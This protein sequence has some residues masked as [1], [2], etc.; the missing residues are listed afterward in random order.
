VEFLRP[1]EGSL[2]ETSRQ[3]FE[4]NPLRV[5]DSK[6]PQD[7]EIVANAPSVLDVLGPEDIA[8]F[9]ALKR[10]LDA[11][12]VTYTVDAGLVRGLDYYTRTLFEIRS[13]AGE[14]GAQNT[15][16]GGG[17]YDGMVRSLGG[18]PVPAIGFA[19]GLER[20]LL[21]M[22]DATPAV[23][24][25]CFIAPIGERATAVGLSLARD[26]RSRG[27]RAELDGRGNSVKSMMRRADAA[28]ARL[29]IVLGD[30]E[31]ATAEVVIKDLRDREMAPEAVSVS[32]AAARVAERLRQIVAE[33]TS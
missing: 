1:L 23:T 26:V 28:G 17:R 33:G 32:E 21:A 18:P 15:L 8:H 3:R 9:E 10:H 14:L 6:A 24:P 5:L 2:S 16:V 12:G 20:I 4:T 13:D 31:V 11:L 22:S 19:M 30:A 25:S 27:Q 29:C 7:I